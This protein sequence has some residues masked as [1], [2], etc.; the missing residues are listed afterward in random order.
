MKLNQSFRPRIRFEEALF[1]YLFYKGLVE[2]SLNASRSC[3]NSNDVSIVETRGRVRLNGIIVEKFGLRG[4]YG[5]V[6]GTTN[7]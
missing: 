7:G 3:N 4:F 5:V 2:V 1:F 6:R